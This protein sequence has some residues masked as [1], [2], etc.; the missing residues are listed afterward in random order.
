MINTDSVRVSVSHSKQV[1]PPV[2]LTRI[3]MEE[4]KK[5]ETVILLRQN[6]KDSNAT[7]E[8]GATKL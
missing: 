3:S 1:I 7:L 5:E 8:E 6:Y 4:S 2:L